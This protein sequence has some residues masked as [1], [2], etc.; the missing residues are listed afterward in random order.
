MKIYKGERTEILFN[1]ER[2]D[3][4]LVKLV[5]QKPDI[6]WDFVLIP[7][8]NNCERDKAEVQRLNPPQDYVELVNDTISCSVVFPIIC[9]SFPVFKKVMNT[10]IKRR[11]LTL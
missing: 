5:P 6:A 8:G 2:G 7:W 10:N 1:D 11:N 9:K 4:V 3:M